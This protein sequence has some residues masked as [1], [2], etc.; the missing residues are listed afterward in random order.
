MLIHASTALP[1]RVLPLTYA[2]RS[3]SGRCFALLAIDAQALDGSPHS[4]LAK[5]HGKGQHAQSAP[6]SNVATPSE[7]GE[8]R[9][10]WLTVPLSQDA[11]PGD[12][13][14]SIQSGGKVLAEGRISLRDHVPYSNVQGARSALNTVIGECLLRLSQPLLNLHLWHEDVAEEIIAMTGRANRYLHLRLLTPENLD[15]QL[16]EDFTKRVRKTF[17]FRSISRLKVPARGRDIGGLMGALQSGM[18]G[19]GPTARPQLFAHTKK[20]AYLP[21]AAQSDWRRGLLSPLIEGRN[22]PQAV[23]QLFFARTALVCSAERACIE[24]F[25]NIAGPRKQSYELASSLAESLFGWKPAKLIFSAGSMFWFRADRVARVWSADK[26][27]TIAA[28]LEPSADMT[29]PSYAHAFERLFPGAIA[30]FGSKVVF[31]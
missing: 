14:L 13:Q 24:P 17:R 23:R 15:D 25:A 19:R 6:E 8:E 5:I 28:K 27:E 18:N 26:L 4:V 30:H 2:C 11:V 22:L 16:A 7:Y 12:F 20:T 3:A 21:A 1:E 29:E 10:V 9:W 31:T